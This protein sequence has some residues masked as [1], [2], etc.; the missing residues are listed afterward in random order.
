MKISSEISP[1]RQKILKDAYAISLIQFTIFRNEISKKSTQKL[2]NIN[3]IFIPQPISQNQFESNS[4]LL[5]K[6]MNFIDQKTTII[7]KI[8]GIYFHFKIM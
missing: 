4:E 2:K 3:E 8:P 6:Q 5:Y 7:K 1:R